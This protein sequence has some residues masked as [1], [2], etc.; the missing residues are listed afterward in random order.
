MPPA[1]MKA[2]AIKSAMRLRCSST[3]AGRLVFKVESRKSKGE[4]VLNPVMSDG[5][6]EIIG[7]GSNLPTRELWEG[8]HVR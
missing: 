2:D 5:L 1:T 7:V 8:R 3:D 4:R 6:W